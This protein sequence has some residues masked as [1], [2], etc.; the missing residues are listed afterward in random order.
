LATIFGFMYRFRAK[1]SNDSGRGGLR[2]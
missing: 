2:R 1:K